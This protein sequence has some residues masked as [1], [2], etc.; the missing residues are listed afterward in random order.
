MYAWRFG[1]GN[2]DFERSQFSALLR[3]ERESG[4]AT[5]LGLPLTVSLVRLLLCLVFA[6]IIVH[7][8]S[9]LDLYAI[10]FN[11][12][13]IVM[14]RQSETIFIWWCTN[15]KSSLENKLALLVIDLYLSKKKR[16]DVQVRLYCVFLVFLV[17]YLLSC[18]F[19]LSI[20]NSWQG[21]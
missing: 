7:V 12:V 15:Y 2:G 11:T 17:L 9:I 19:F 16:W 5:W 8:S 3:V 20:S 4:D 18:L 1:Q 21:H 14:K 6:T 10:D 13:H